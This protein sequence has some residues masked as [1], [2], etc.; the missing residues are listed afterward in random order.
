MVMWCLG[1]IFFSELYTSDKNIMDV[2]ESL[3]LGEFTKLMK[4]SGLSSELDSDARYTAFVPT[5]QA[6]SALPSETL[7]ELANNK[8][9]LRETLLLHLA[10]GKTV[11]ET[12][13]DNGKIITLDGSQELRV[14]VADEGEVLQQCLNS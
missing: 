9:V 13:K 12:M 6:F 2:A 14:N 10:A 5:D 4:T 8:E 3:G 11:T 1:S 7:K